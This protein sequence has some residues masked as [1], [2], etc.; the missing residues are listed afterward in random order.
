MDNFVISDLKT[1][2]IVASAI[3]TPLA[4]ALLVAWRT[5]SFLTILSRL[6]SLFHGKAPSA[7]PFINEYLSTQSAVVQLV[8][9]TGAKVRTKKHAKRVVDWCTKHDESL[10]EA[11][12]CG[13]YFDWELPGLNETRKRNPLPS[14]LAVLAF[15]ACAGG[16]FAIAAYDKPILRVNGTSTW[17]GITPDYAQ[18][19]F[20]SQILA[21]KQCEEISLNKTDH[22]GRSVQDFK[23]LC[24]IFGS[25]KVEDRRTY[26]AKELRE[27]K[28][29]AGVYS[30]VFLLMM[31]IPI[32][33]LA[34]QERAKKMQKRLRL[35]A[36]T[37]SDDETQEDSIDVN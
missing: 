29:V 26:I 17:F 8:F 28:I 4:L 20:S 35:N 21:F 11:V 18:P 25:E 12:R 32:R 7:V 23:L 9:S 2:A 34:Q 27:Q 31:L 19:L 3:G 5:K 24:R 37:R 16:L 1:F 13:P 36:T 6:W 10:E 14:F 33:T 22:Q 15:C 30:V